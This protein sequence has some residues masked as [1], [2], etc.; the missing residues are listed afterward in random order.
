M[1]PPTFSALRRRFG[2]D[3]EA[4]TTSLAL[5]LGGAGDPMN[6]LSYLNGLGVRVATLP[7]LLAA[8]RDLPDEEELAAFE[9]AE[10]VAVSAASDGRWTLFLP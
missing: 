6:V 9:V 10:G 8:I 1:R 4:C 3:G 2:G 7:T 5:A